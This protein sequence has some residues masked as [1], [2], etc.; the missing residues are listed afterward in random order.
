MSR[1][2]KWM[3]RLV[4]GMDLPGEPVPGQP[5]IELAGENRVLIEHHLGVTGYAPE[6]IRVKVCYGQVSIQG[7]ALELR[8]MTRGQLVISGQIY[9]VTLLRG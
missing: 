7:N 8:R 3:E 6:E 9:R 1:S 5:V 4:E 2:E